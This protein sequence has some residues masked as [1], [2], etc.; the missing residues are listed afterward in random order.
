MSN[1]AI[2]VSIAVNGMP[3][4]V[5][6]V[7]E[8]RGQTF[9]FLIS[10]RKL[11]NETSDPEFLS[12][13]LMLRILALQFRFDPRVVLAPEISEILRDLYGTHTWR[14]NVDTECF[15]AQ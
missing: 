4:S 12:P 5:L 8:I 11:E 7:K 2:N 9:R 3:R 13:P 15:A 10:R 6:Q 14:Q 1:A